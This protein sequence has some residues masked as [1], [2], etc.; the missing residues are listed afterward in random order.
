MTTT[1][2][3]PAPAR[4][5]PSEHPCFDEQARFRSARVH[6]PVAPRCNV[7][8]NYCNRKSDCVAENRPG[9]C[10]TKLTPE[11]ALDYVDAV[12][13]DHPNLAVVGIAGPGDA[14]ANPRETLATLRG[15]R[16]RHPDLL[17]CVSTN[18]LGLPAHLDE[19]AELGVSHVTVTMN[20]VDPQV[21]GRIYRWVRDDDKR[22]HRGTKAGELLIERQL[23]G[24]RGL[25]ERRIFTKVNSLLVPG[26]TLEGIADVAAVC[27]QIGVDTM[28]CLP[29]IPVEGTPFCELGAPTH[30]QI[31]TA[32]HDAGAHLPQMTHCQRCRADAVGMLD[33]E[34]GD[35]DV[36]RLM[37][38]RGAR[39]DRPLVAVCSQEGYLVN[40][41]LGG[42]DHVLIY[43]L[44][45]E[46]VPEF[47]ERRDTPAAGGG[48][49]RW[50]YLA[51]VLHDCRALITYQL[52]GSPRQVLESAGIA[53]HESEGLID[54]A[55]TDLY[56]GREPRHALPP[57][58]CR[59]EC[60]GDGTGCG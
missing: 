51:G 15:V 56:A 5:A 33:D 10:S 31:T 13:A 32:R 4:L 6:L 59:T 37:A 1:P 47:V 57:R 14:F 49:A 35:D 54:E 41:H 30:D 9:V 24:L 11:Q 26:V 20:T 38:S 12:R 29:M 27:A 7:Q 39:R 34:F 52:G 44:S 42:A 17:L 36:A 3:P 18:G 16:E 23:A 19:L 46:G 8:C 53:V 55:V 21:A 50:A 58:D 22:I 2:A 25:K 40:Q 28:N 45:P 43:R 48:A 60:A